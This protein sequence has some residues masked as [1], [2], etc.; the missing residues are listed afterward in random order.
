LREF[1]ENHVLK[2]ENYYFQKECSQLFLLNFR[3]AGIL[4]EEIVDETYAFVFWDIYLP[5]LQI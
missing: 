1:R 5:S 4:L 2:S 3:A